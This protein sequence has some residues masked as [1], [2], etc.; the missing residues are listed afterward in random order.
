MVARPVGFVAHARRR[1]VKL[2]ANNGLNARFPST[3]V[4]LRHAEHVAVIRNSD[5]GL[6]Q[7]GCP[8]DQLLGVGGAVEKG[9]VRVA[10]EVAESGHRRGERQSG[11][12]A[13]PPQ[14]EGMGG[15]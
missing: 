8:R 4:E 13:T 2:A 5:G 11:K 14:P 9:V 1:D 12:R 6:P 7:F 10:V 15:V 3:E